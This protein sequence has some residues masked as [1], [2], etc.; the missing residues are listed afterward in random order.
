MIELN[1]PSKS[2]LLPEFNINLFNCYIDED[3]RKQ[4]K[5][6]VLAEEANILSIPT[7][8]NPNSGDWLTSRLW[9]YNFLEFKYDCVKDF[10]NFIYNSYKQYMSNI[11]VDSNN[12]VY[13]HCWANIIRR[14]GRTISAHH[15]ANVHGNLKI[16]YFY[17]YVSGNICIDVQETS[18]F[19]AHP[20]LGS[21]CGPAYKEIPNKNAEMILFPSFMTHWV[22]ENKN[23]QPRITISFDI[24]TE[25]VYNILNNINYRLLTLR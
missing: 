20:L 1:F 2:P 13:I 3:I 11:G 17:S 8:D 23:E 19:F 22:S 15:H 5:D 14:G 25:E 12:S 9:Y 16:P 10:H 24:V 21:A 4:L 18:T 7:P 6:V